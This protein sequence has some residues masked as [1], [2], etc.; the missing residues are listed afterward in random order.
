MQHLEW[1]TLQPSNGYTQTVKSVQAV[2]LALSEV[3]GAFISRVPVGRI[4][5]IYAEKKSSPHTTERTTVGNEDKRF[6][7]HEVLSAAKEH[8]MLFRFVVG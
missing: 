7:L 1:T 2:E 3:K 8:N 5:V 4:S 6:F